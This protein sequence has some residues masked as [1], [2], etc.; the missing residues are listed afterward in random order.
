MQHIHSM[1]LTHAAAMY[2][3]NSQ[4]NPLLNNVSSSLIDCTFLKDMQDAVRIH[5]IKMIRK[6]PIDPHM[7]A[8]NWGI[9]NETA[10]R[11]LKVMTPHGVQGKFHHKCRQAAI[12]VK[13]TEPHTSW[14]NTAES[15]IHELKR[16]LGRKMVR[17]GAPRCLWDHCLE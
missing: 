4:S 2:M 7:L 1:H 16:G 15:A 5:S 11:T 12:H 10:K 6:E 14:S 13:Q 17:S 8:S 3:V 9:G